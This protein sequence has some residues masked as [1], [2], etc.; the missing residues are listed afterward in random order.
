MYLFKNSRS[1]VIIDVG[2]IKYDTLHDNTVG[3]YNGSFCV[4]TAKSVYACFLLV[5]HFAVLP[6]A[7]TYAEIDKDI[8]L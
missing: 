7:G 3:V 4:E 2:V 1:S 6:A 8:N 5:L